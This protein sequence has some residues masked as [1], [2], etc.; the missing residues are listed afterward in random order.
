MRTIQDE[1][2]NLI[3]GFENYGYRVDA[4]AIPGLEEEFA[5]TCALA[6]PRSR[7]PSTAP[8]EP[9]AFVAGAGRL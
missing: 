2:Q 9:T 8:L 7:R 6:S 5:N 3:C 1:I 4:E